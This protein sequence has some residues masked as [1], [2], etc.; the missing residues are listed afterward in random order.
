MAA[1]NPLRNRLASTRPAPPPRSQKVD[2]TIHTLRSGVVRVE[3]AEPSLYAS[4]DTVADK[5]RARTRGRAGRGGSH[6]RGPGVP[7]AARLLSGGAAGGGLP[8]KAP[9]PPNQDPDNATLVT[10]PP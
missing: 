8:G 10:L 9:P 4:I 5:A 6:S 2:V 7:G 1:L 3:D